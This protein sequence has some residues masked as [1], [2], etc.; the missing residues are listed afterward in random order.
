MTIRTLAADGGLQREQQGRTRKQKKSVASKFQLETIF[1]QRDLPQKK[2][3][4]AQRL[5][6]RQNVVHGFL[7]VLP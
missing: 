4:L 3:A 1:L 5:E 2:S 7:G 6:I